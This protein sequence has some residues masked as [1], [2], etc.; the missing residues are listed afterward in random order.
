MNAAT[1]EKIKAELESVLTGRTVGK[2][3]QLSRTEL[4][5][6]FRLS[7]SR[8][9][10]LNYEPADPRIFLIRR[11]LKDLEKSTG[12]PSPFALSLKKR[13]SG[14]SIDSIHQPPGE[15]LLDFSLSV[16]DEL[17]EPHKYTLVAQ[18]TGRSSN[19]FLLNSNGA[20][21]DAARETSF[22]GQAIGENYVPPSQ[23][24]SV[25]TSEKK[26][27]LA[28][29]SKRAAHLKLSTRFTRNKRQSSDS[30]RW[31]RPPETD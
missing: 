26:S 31:P 29:H 6:D 10:Y 5:I 27:D 3:F 23:D 30:S 2:V 25:A 11:R 4:A 16:T 17:G 24:A 13:L 14:A 8:Y 22:E 9:L 20:I 12:N 28:V 7:D 18:L 19:L 15:R 1:L 21:L